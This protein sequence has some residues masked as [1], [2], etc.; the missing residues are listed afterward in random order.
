MLRL[1]KVWMLAASITGASALFCVPG[2][3]GVDNVHASGEELAAASVAPR[4]SRPPA[5]SVAGARQNPAP[6]NSLLAGAPQL[7]QVSVQIEA[8]TSDA[9]VLNFT[10][11][12]ANQPQTYKNFVA[13]WEATVIPWTAPPL[14]KI[15]IPFNKQSGT[16]I[17]DGLTT[18]KSSYIVG[19][20]VGPAVTTICASSL[21]NAGD[22]QQPPSSIQIGLK[23]VGANSVAVTYQTLSG[24]LP[25]TSDNWVGLWRGSVSPYNSPKPLAV[26]PVPSDSTEGTLA[27]NNVEIALDSTYTLIYFMGG[28]ASTTNNTAAA[29]ILTFNTARG[30]P[31]AAAR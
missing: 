1:I 28:S 14:K 26:A 22:V 18:T 9:V 16:F 8:Y 31:P 10:G 7:N 4:P 12:P 27:I 23:Y 3:V 25:R 2:W 5:L 15:E 19:Y 20:G 11:L 17:I 30:N 29:A 13:I 24:Y 21:L 6:S